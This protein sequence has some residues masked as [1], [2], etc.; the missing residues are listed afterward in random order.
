VYSLTP[1]E[2]ATSN[3]TAELLLERL[4]GGNFF[5]NFQQHSRTSFGKI[6][7]EKLKDSFIHSSRNLS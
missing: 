2:V 7:N 4:M 1:E 3:R 5:A 6:D